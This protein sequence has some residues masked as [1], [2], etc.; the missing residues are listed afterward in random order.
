MWV[1]WVLLG[2]HQRDRRPRPGLQQVV[3]ARFVAKVLQTESVAVEVGRAGQVEDRQDRGHLGVVD[4]GY[5]RM[6]L[7][8]ARCRNVVILHLTPSSH[9]RREREN[10]PV[11]MAANRVLT[12][13]AT[14]PG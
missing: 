10:R 3:A 2:S 9:N 14:S 4:L 11:S 7:V 8:S 1:L 6:S 13:P 12:C 5:L